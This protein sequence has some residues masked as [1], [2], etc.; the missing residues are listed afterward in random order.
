VP[1]HRRAPTEESQYQ[2]AA[3]N[4]S[5][6]A[7]RFDELAAAAIARIERDAESCPTVDDKPLMPGHGQM[8]VSQASSD[9]FYPELEIF[10]TLHDPDDDKCSLWHVREAP[11]EVDQAVT[12]R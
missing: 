8:R 12:D 7:Q 2:E 1:L 11:P 3:K 4:V 5:A 6:D 9:P 10:F